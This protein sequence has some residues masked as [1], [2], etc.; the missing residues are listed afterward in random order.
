MQVQS[1][2]DERDQLL[3]ALEKERWQQRQLEK[4]L[5]EATEAHSQ[6]RKVRHHADV[7]GV[8]HVHG[9]LRVVSSWLQS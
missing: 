6:M 3:P 4:R 9:I 8:L 7:T 2:T 1:L 5:A